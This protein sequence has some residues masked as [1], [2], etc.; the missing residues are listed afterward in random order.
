MGEKFSEER[1]RRR[2]RRERRW[3]GALEV[4]L[5]DGAWRSLGRFGGDF[6]MG[7]WLLRATKGP[8]SRWLFDL[9]SSPSLRHGSPRL[10]T[11]RG[12]NPFDGWSRRADV[13]GP[14]PRTNS[15]LVRPKTTTC[16]PHP[17]NDPSRRG[18]LSRAR[19][20]RSTTV[21]TRPPVA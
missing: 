4:R 6:E 15:G 3:S 10:P 11:R 14:I 1:R 12:T 8:K 20:S 7:R 16:Q 18:V 5:E 21:S 13:G 9:G 17:R 19:Q 2:R